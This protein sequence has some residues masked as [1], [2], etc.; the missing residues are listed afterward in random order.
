MFLNFK[1][2]NIWTQNICR[3]SWKGKNMELNHND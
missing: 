3:N 1:N 2:F